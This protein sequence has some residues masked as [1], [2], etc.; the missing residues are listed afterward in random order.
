M[1]QLLRK[2]CVIKLVTYE[3]IKD[4]EGGYVKYFHTHTDR[5]N[6]SPKLH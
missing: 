5:I 6:F 4:Y 2:K 1:L 3:N